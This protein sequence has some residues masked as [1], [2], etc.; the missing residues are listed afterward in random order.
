MKRAPFWQP[1]PYQ[2]YPYPIMYRPLHRQWVLGYLPEQQIDHLLGHAIA[3]NRTKI[4][5]FASEDMFGQRLLSIPKT[6]W[7]LLV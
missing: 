1:L 5:I 2:R 4:A 6:G 3:Q 7:P